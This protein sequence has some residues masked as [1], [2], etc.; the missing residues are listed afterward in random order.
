MAYAARGRGR[1]SR[2]EKG[3]ESL[4]PTQRDI[5]ALVAEGLTNPEIAERLFISPR[6]VQ[7]HLRGAYAKLGVT[8]RR[9]LRQALSAGA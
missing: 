8:S 5:V 6:T 4:T 3:P 9:Q 7:S 2:A 1:R